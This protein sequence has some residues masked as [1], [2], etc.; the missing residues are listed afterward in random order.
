MRSYV[1]LNEEEITD[2]KF[3]DLIE[4]WRRT[5]FASSFRFMPEEYMIL[6]GR[7]VADKL[8]NPIRICDINVRTSS[9]MFQ[10]SVI[11]GKIHELPHSSHPLPPENYMNPRFDVDLAKN[12]MLK[13]GNVVAAAKIRHSLNI[14]SEIKPKKV[15]FNDP[16]TIVYWEDGSKTVVKAEGEDFDPEKGLAMAIAKKYLGN[17]G[18]YYDVF[19][20]WLPK[21]NDANDSVEVK[22]E[23]CVTCKHWKCSLTLEPCRSCIA[24][25]L[26]K[27]V[28][29]NYEKF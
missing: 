19:R 9:T 28:K 1:F 5:A 15:I 23:P 22:N 16:A 4:G 12:Q 29:R 11:F 26:K 7:A 21:D 13:T 25:L 6:I 24:T 17:K 2:E 27:G 3:C 14:S 10:N 18:N 20:K 8:N